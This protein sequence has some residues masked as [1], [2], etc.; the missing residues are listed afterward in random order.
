[1]HKHYYNG[2][3]R[4]PKHLPYDRCIENNKSDLEIKLSESDM[5]ED[6]LRNSC[7]HHKI[8]TNYYDTVTQYCNITNCSEC[9]YYHYIK[10]GGKQK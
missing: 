10:Q 2:I 5:F 8:G 3:F 6:K 1:M 9:K 4:I 7:L